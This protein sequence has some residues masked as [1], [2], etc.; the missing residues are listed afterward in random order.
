MP[1]NQQTNQGQNDAEHDSHGKN[2]MHIRHI[3]TPY[4]SAKTKD[5]VLEDLLFFETRKDYLSLALGLSAC[6]GTAC[7]RR[8]AS[9]DRMPE[10]P[11][12]P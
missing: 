4:T 8:G 9:R 12:Q 5:P 6:A 1:T 10:L 7:C 11:S 3:N 2:I